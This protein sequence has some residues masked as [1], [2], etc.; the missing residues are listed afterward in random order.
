M[1]S[2][3]STGYSMC[4]PIK[5]G[6]H[7]FYLVYTAMPRLTPQL[8][9]TKSDWQTTSWLVSKEN[10]DFKLPHLNSLSSASSCLGWE[11][12]WQ[13]LPEWPLMSDHQDMQIIEQH[14]QKP[15]LYE[16][17]ESPN[18]QCWYNDSLGFDQK[19]CLQ[20]TN[21][22]TI[23]SPLHCIHWAQ[24]KSNWCISREKYSS[25]MNTSL[26]SAWIMV[27]RSNEIEWYLSHWW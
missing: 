24:D 21:P 20:K 2:D 25:W 16:T 8:R 5:S 10:E 1:L 17:L 23:I 13:P 6:L 12:C 15:C 11:Q 4:S 19:A 3:K 7:T 14:L 26:A 9:P 27:K 18:H 22:G